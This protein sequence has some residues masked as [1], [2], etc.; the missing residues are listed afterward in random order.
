MAFTTYTELQAEIKGW[1]KRSNISDLLIEGFI[2]LAESE[3]NKT[4]RTRNQEKRESF[5]INSEYTDLTTLTDT[6]L[7]MRSLQLTTDPVTSLR[8]MTPSQMDGVYSGSGQPVFF[9]IMGDE[10]QVSP[11]PDDSY[12]AEATF[13]SPLPVLSDTNTANW[14]LTNHPDLYLWGALYF[15]NIYIKDQ[16]EAQVNKL[17][18]DAAIKKLN[19][20]ERRAR[21]SGSALRQRTRR[22]NP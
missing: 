22:N 2:S 8:Y 17:L 13:F 21:H 6:V 11:T 20:Q 15:G 9:S 1:L 7:E 16:A 10:L 12:T 3:M 5:T 14:V 4:L 18:F 19:T